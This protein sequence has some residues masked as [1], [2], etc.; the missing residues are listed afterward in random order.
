MHPAGRAVL[1][2]ASRALFPRPCLC[3][4]YHLDWYVGN[5]FNVKSKF[6]DAM[7]GEGVCVFLD[8]IVQ[9]RLSNCTA[10]YSW[11][12]VGHLLLLGCAD[13]IPSVFM[14]ST[15][16]EYGS[17]GY[18][19]QS[20]S[21][22]AEQQKC[23]SLVPVCALLFGPARQVRPSRPSPCLFSTLRLNLVLTLGMSP[24]FRDGVHILLYIINR[25]RVI[26]E[27]IGS[28]K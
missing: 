27:F 26:P 18:G 1:P 8:C 3:F 22:L 2:R 5:T 15:S 17:T 6:C 10:R 19:C 13:I 20:C 23:F 14:V 16:T 4:K 24:P 7:W 11:V 28:S 12:W 9:R 21:W 25:H